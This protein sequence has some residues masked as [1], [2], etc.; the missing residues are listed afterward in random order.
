MKTFGLHFFFYSL[1]LLFL[2][3]Y[4]LKKCASKFI[5]GIHF[6]L[7]DKKKRVE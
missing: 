7:P 5:D 4:F 3:D 2:I 6:L 1:P